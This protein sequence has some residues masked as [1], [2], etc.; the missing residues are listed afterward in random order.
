MDPTNRWDSTPDNERWLRDWAFGNAKAEDTEL[1]ARE[2]LIDRDP[3][4]ITFQE[5]LSRVVGS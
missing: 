1:A 2:D 4:W 3:A 5:R